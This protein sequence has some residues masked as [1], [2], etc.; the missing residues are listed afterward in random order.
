[1]SKILVIDDEESIRLTFRAFLE[2]EGH[3]VFLAQGYEDALGL[4]DEA[5]DLVFVDILLDA[6]SGMEILKVIRDRGLVCPVVLVTGEPSLETATQALRLG[7]YDYLQKPVNKD[8]L[9]RVTR[10]ALRLKQLEDEKRTLEAERS[11][12]RLHLE[13]VFQS[14]PEAIISL[15]LQGRILQTNRATVDLFGLQPAE[16]EGSDYE[17]S[18][19]HFHEAFAQL[20]R[21]TLRHRKHV[22]EFR[23]EFRDIIGDPRT[24][25][26]DASP[27]IDAD[28]GFIGVVLVVRDITRLAGLEKELRE[29]RSYGNMVGKNQ[30]MREIYSLLEDLART[31]TT[32]LITGDSGTGKELIAEALHYSGPRAKKPLVRVNCSALSEN[33]LESELFGHVRGAF[34]GAVRDKVG[35]FKLAHGGTIFL[36]EIGD[37]SP[38]IQLKLLRVLQEKEIERVGD[39]ATMKVDVRVVAATNQNLRERVACGEF[40]EDLY[41]R[42]K[43]VE[44]KLPPLRERRDDIPL[45]IDHFVRS[46]NME[47]DRH[48]NGLTEEARSALMNYPWPGNIRELKHAVEHA[49][50]L[51]RGQTIEAR[52][53]PAEILHPQEIMANI[54]TQGDRVVDRGALQNALER[55]GGNKAKAA[56]I[57][58][59]SRQTVYRKLREFEMA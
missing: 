6:M 13:A 22:R 11:S 39:T 31:D 3:T 4:L 14:V 30:R 8:A 46:F 36:D 29:R 9:L 57:L 28:G 7:A 20:V 27:L 17:Q 35:R 10:Q 25:V 55:A 50:V 19:G 32:V 16:L 15:D 37:I 56:R 33:L 23:I 2:R 52:H 58:G 18:L 44:I 41:Y 43:V 24:A 51:C 21:E 38:R 59:V 1:M 45:L 26:L 54:L 48:I 12:L 47:M 49:F 42:L 53:L 34:T 5:P 40:R